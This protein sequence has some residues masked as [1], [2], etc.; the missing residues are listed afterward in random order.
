VETIQT[1]I[2]ALVNVPG[3]LECVTNDRQRY[4]YVDYAHTPDA[5]ES[6]LLALRGLTAD[7]IICIFGCGGDRDRNKRPKMGAIAVQLSD[8]TIVTSDNPRTEPP[9]EIIKEILTGVRA[10]CPLAYQIAELENSG[11][12][13]KGYVVEADRA[14]AIDLGVRISQPG[15]TILIAGKGHEPYQIIGQQKHVF[16]DRREAA[17]ALSEL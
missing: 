10:I 5:L 12:D 17:R 2:E 7:R 14:K 6:A 3:R 1:G 13:N 15:D 4:V 16:D 11:F 8:L 9:L